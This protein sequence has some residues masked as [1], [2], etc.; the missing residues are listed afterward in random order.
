MGSKD[1][2]TSCSVLPLLPACSTAFLV[3]SGAVSLRSPCP[4]SAH[5]C[6]RETHRAG[7]QCIIAALQRARDY[8]DSS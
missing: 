5:P 3:L 2:G 7:S 8:G 4:S 1:G 6:P